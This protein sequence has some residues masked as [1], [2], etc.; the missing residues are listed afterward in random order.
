[1]SDLLAFSTN[2]DITVSGL[3]AFASRASRGST[4]KSD[5]LPPP[6]GPRGQRARYF[7]SASLFE[8]SAYLPNGA[9][10]AVCK[11]FLGQGARAGPVGLVRDGEQQ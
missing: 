11:T 8:H 9:V 4:Y 7:S 1:M 6:N 10:A 3:V 5:V 2:A